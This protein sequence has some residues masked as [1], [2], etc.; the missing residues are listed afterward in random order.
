M[1]KLNLEVDRLIESRCCDF[2][3]LLQLLYDLP[4]L[5]F[6]LGSADLIR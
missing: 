5:S 6:L 2:L 1:P 3:S 4:N